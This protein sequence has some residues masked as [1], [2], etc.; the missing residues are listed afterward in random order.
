MNTSN[1]SKNIVIITKQIQ[2]EANSFAQK[3]NKRLIRI[4]QTDEWGITYWLGQN[5]ILRITSNPYE[6]E[7]AN[8]YQGN[9]NEYIVNVIHNH[10]VGISTY[11]IVSESLNPVTSVHQNGFNFILNFLR[12]FTNDFNKPITLLFGE[13]IE[14]GYNG[15]FDQYLLTNYPLASELYTNFVNMHQEMKL[16]KS[17]LILGPN[18]INI[19]LKNNHLALAPLLTYN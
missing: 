14:A 15:D 4:V 1:E 18:L 13:L 17:P 2:F 11:C 9:A 19:G 8:R 6:F 10:K 12:K 3:I 5:E 16:I 7:I